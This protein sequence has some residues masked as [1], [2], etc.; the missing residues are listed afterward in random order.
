MYSTMKSPGKWSS[1]QDWFVR[2]RVF[3]HQQRGQAGGD[4]ARDQLVARQKGVRAGEAVA[5][6]AVVGVNLRADHAPV[7]H[8]VRAVGDLRAG[9]W[10]MQDER[11][12][13]LDLHGRISLREAAHESTQARRIQVHAMPAEV[14][15]VL[16]TDRVS[17]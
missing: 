5:A 9:D 7:R 12:D 2:A 16:P 8:G 13:G 10:H 15:G 14:T 6:Q 17:R 11:R 1:N 3:A 4:A